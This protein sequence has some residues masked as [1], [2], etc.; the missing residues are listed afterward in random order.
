M[1]GGLGSYSN[2]MSVCRYFDAG[3]NTSGRTN[4]QSNSIIPVYISVG[5]LA[6]AAMAFIPGL[7]LADVG[8]D[9]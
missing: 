2:L 1:I 8:L 6:I 4:G 7:D 9:Y 3:M 5:G